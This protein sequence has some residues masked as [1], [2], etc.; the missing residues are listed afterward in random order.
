RGIA[1]RIRITGYVPR[2]S[3]FSYCRVSDLFVFASMTETQG[4][5]LLEAMSTGLPVVAIDAMGVSD[6]QA[7]EVGGL[8]SSPD[9]REF[10]D[11]VAQ[12]LDNRELYERKRRG[13]VNKARLWSTDPMTRRLVA[14]YEEAI[15]DY[16]IHGLPRYHRRNWEQD[17]LPEI[18]WPPETPKMTRN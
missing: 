15:R 4:L 17:P 12:L 14:C 11:K 6:L 16:R 5:V 3:V 8:L 9:R 1:E 7:D 18:Q 2:E 10:A 13:A